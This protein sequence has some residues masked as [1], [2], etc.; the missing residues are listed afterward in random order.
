M[1]ADDRK[2]TKVG[3]CKQESL[4][5]R[6]S[7]SEIQC[8]RCVCLKHL[9]LAPAVYSHLTSKKMQ[10][11]CCE[12]ALFNSYLSPQVSHGHYSALSR[13]LRAA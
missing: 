2:N 5:Y 13:L 12:L 7:A 9:Q 3:R 6:Y 10:V 8:Y 4:I 1:A 11:E